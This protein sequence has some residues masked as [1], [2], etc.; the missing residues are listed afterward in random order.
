VK[1]AERLKQLH[2]AGIERGLCFSI[3]VAQ[4]SAWACPEVK[5]Y[6]DYRFALFARAVERMGKIRRELKEESELF[7]K[8]KMEGFFKERKARPLDDLPEWGKASQEY[9]LRYLVF[10]ANGGERA[11]IERRWVDPPHWPLVYQDGRALIFGYDEGGR[12]ESFARFRLSFGSEAFGKVPTERRTQ[13]VASFPDKAPGFGELYLHGKQAT[14][15]ALSDFNWLILY[16]QVQPQWTEH[17]IATTIVTQSH[18]SYPPA[19]L[20]F[21]TPYSTYWSQENQK[22]LQEQ[23][24]TGA[25]LSRWQSLH[26]GRWASIAL[27]LNPDIRVL[28]MRRARQALAENPR[29]V[30]SYEKL[31]V[32]VDNLKTL[33]NAWSRPVVVLGQTPL[34]VTIRQLQTLTALKSLLTLEPR[35]PDIHERVAELYGKMN[36]LDV[37]QEHYALALKNM[38]RF[39]APPGAKDWP[40][41]VQHRKNQFKK[42]L[43]DLEEGVNNFAGLKRLS[44][45]FDSQVAGRDD[46]LKQSQAAFK[47]GFARKGLSL[48]EKIEIKDLDLFAKRNLAVTQLNILLQLGKVNQVRSHLDVDVKKLFLEVDPVDMRWH[49]MNAVA[50]SIL[51][52]YAAVEK[53]LA[54]LETPLASPQ[55]HAVA[56]REAAILPHVSQPNPIVAAL[57]LHAHVMYL[58][59]HVAYWAS[60]T[61][62]ADLRLTRA[63]MALEHGDTELAARHFAKVLDLTQGIERFFPDRAIAQEYLLRL[64]RRQ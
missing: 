46:P 26:P 16:A 14:S 12:D 36:Y 43:Q 31:A 11:N 23:D 51:G 33:E 8:N 6:Y 17:V 50:A 35:N 18:G 55:R 47:L 54:E 37:A 4:Y 32:A 53:S 27:G 3:D 1:T 19:S 9:Q 28:M 13:P 34:R 38:D 49:H 10:P 56:M 5:H 21:L 22:K 60:F 40:Q 45:E 7:L 61:T 63:L 52:D 58:R 29:N 24:K 20:Y 41:Y 42:K 15:L 39:P 2:D 59:N 57:G 25:L 44:D 30:L 48:L 62:A 64:E